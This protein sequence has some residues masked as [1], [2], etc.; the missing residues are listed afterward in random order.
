MIR[1]DPTAE[2]EDGAVVG[3]G[4]VIWQ[5]AHLRSG[6]RLGRECVVGRGV[7]VGPGTK[8]GDRCKIENYALVYEP[9]IVEDGAFIGPAVVFT[10]DLHPRAITPRGELKT[11]ADWD[12]VGVRVGRGASIGA[13]AV[14]VAPVRIGA[15]AT[16]AAGA[17]VVKDAPDYALVAGIPARQIGWVG[18][19]GY[20]LKPDGEI[21]AGAKAWLCPATGL[22]YLELNGHLRR[23]QA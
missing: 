23:E 4:T 16:V 6:T 14:C 11:A 10:N 7:Y 9:A 2:V 19:A 21:G 8:I 18:E 17:V 22:R 5:Y 13:R 1:I 3:D 12:A 20:Q 15:W